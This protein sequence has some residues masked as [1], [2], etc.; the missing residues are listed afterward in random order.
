M[1]ACVCRRVEGVEGGVVVGEMD[2]W[3]RDLNI[4]AGRSSFENVSF[5]RPTL[6]DV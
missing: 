3:V 2:C 4:N 5:F 1:I 6:D